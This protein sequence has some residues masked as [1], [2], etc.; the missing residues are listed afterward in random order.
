MAA[1]NPDKNSPELPT[2]LSGINPGPDSVGLR[3]RAAVVIP[4]YNEAST[5]ADIVK[6]AL[7]QVRLVIV[8]DDGS[9]DDT[10]KVLSDLPVAVLQNPVNR[11]K[12]ASLLRGI[13]YALKQG[14]AA[15]ITLDG[16]GQHRPEDIPLLLTMAE[17]CPRRIVIG[18]RLINKE[19]SPRRRYYA[20]R[21][22]DFWISWAAGYPIV[23]SQ[24]GFRLYPADLLHQPRIANMTGRAFVFESEILIEAARLG[25]RGTAVPIAAIYGNQA[26]ASHFRPVLDISRIVRMVAWKL[27]SRGFYPQGIYRAFIRPPR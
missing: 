6:R 26:R 8:V 5:I 22:A 20:N 21:V 10:A 7:A 23:D 17:R 27:I 11:G 24:S 16:D 9:R 13:H 18:A 3:D 19:A 14:A 4:A 2:A 25:Y 15:V 12:G 1:I